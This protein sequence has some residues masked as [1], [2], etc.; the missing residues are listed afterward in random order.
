M[1]ATNLV[2]LT[3][4]DLSHHEKGVLR[5]IRSWARFQKGPRARP[6][7]LLKSLG[8]H[9]NC[10]LVAGCQRSGTTMLTRIIA[11]SDG[12]RP[13]SLTHDDELDAALVLA[14]YIKLPED[15]RYC[16]Q[17]TYLNERYHEYSRLLPDQ[18][19]IWLLR[20]PYS[21]VYSMVYHWRRSALDRLYESASRDEPGLQ[22]LHEGRAVWQFR[23]AR[24]EKACIAYR[25]KTL[26]TMKIRDLVPAHQLLILD[27]DRIVEGKDA[28]FPAIFDFIGEPFRNSYTQAVKQDS[29]K[30]ANRLSSR[31]RE[32][33]DRIAMPA[34]R[35]CRELA[36]QK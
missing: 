22:Q 31:E 35:T 12:F 27:Y 20:N 6:E 3:R 33:V 23:L 28:A 29:L 16:F 13:L 24:V 9:P 26:Q 30:K 8:N 10:V 1:A 11:G 15:A 5:A 17:T 21:V 34:Y 19:L 2:P 14:G 18:R 7:P 25:Y 36:E 4:E 32:L